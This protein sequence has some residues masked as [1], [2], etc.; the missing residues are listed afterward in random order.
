VTGPFIEHLNDEITYFNEY[1]QHHH[2]RKD[3]DPAVV[4]SI[5]DQPWEGKPVIVLPEVRYEGKELVFTKDYELAY[6]DND[7][8]GTA[9]III[10]GKGAFKGTKTVSFNIVEI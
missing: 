10:R 6:H 1:G 3:I 4:A 2:A 9:S 5:A 7:R 8:P